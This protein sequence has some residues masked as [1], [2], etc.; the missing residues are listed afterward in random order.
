MKSFKKKDNQIYIGLTNFAL[1]LSWISA[2]AQP[3]KTTMI[4]FY[5][6]RAVLTNLCKKLVYTP[7]KPFRVS[8]VVTVGGSMACSLPLG[9]IASPTRV[10]YL[11]WTQKRNTYSQFK[12]WQPYDRNKV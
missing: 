12:K 10:G 9:F 8:N 3:T 2:D 1:S 5:S 7:P 6:L 4:A 11:A